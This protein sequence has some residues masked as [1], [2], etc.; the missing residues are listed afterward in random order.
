[1]KWVRTR[2][3]FFFLTWPKPHIYNS[4]WTEWSAI[5]SEIICVISKIIKGARSLMFDLKLQAWFQTKIAQPE[6]Q[7]PLHSI[8]FQIAQFNSLNRAS[9]HH[10]DNA[11]NQI[12]PFFKLNEIATFAKQIMAFFVFHFPAMWLVSLKSDWLFCF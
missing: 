9:Y 11:N 7:L 8:H 1:M 4:N 2:N 6:I 3:M 10:L 5:W 12:H